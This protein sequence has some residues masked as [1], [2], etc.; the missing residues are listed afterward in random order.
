MF[1]TRETRIVI[2]FLYTDISA[3]L[4]DVFRSPWIYT[5]IPHCVTSRICVLRG[6]NPWTR[7]GPTRLITRHQDIPLLLFRFFHFFFIYVC[8]NPQP[9]TPFECLSIIIIPCGACSIRV[10]TKCPADIREK[11][12]RGGFDAA[13]SISVRFK[14]RHV[15]RLIRISETYAL[16][17]CWRHNRRHALAS[18]GWHTIYRARIIYYLWIWLAR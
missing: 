12:I 11:R 9:T 1:F 7:R 3:G 6:H 2:P 5:F 14:K 8:P 17:C 15:T 10:R 18:K 16:V 13:T 4:S